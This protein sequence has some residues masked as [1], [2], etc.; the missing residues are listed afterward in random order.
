MKANLFRFPVVKSAEKNTRLCNRDHSRDTKSSPLLTE[1][2]NL[3]HVRKNCQ[4]D[5]AW[6]R[7][8]KF[9]AW[10]IL[11][12]DDGSTRRLICF[13]LVAIIAPIRYI[14]DA[15]AVAFAGVI[16]FRI[17]IHSNQHILSCLFA[18][19]EGDTNIPQSHLYVKCHEE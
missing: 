18:H 11:V 14:A 13:G 3:E 16:I 17:N 1:D 10:V 2:N 6:S 12:I 15:E 7:A 4:Q 8:T 5:E 19:Q 9:T